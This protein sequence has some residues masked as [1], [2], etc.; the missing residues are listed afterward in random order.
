M[1]GCPFQLGIAKEITKMRPPNWAK[2]LLEIPAFNEN[3][4]DNEAHTKSS[5]YSTIT[6]Y[7]DVVHFG[8]LV[9]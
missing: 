6:K 2:C 1:N 8:C 3:I 4:N 9:K 5:F 7:A